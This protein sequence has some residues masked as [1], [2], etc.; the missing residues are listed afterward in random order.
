MEQLREQ[1][2]AA[3]A[4]A[5]REHA[6]TPSARTSGQQDAAALLARVRSYNP[7]AS[8]RLITEAFHFAM[9][10][11]EGQ[12]RASGEPY[13]TH[14][15]AVAFIL[16]DL[17]MDDESI[18]AA[19]LHDVVED[20]AA[21]LEEIG[22]RFGPGVA[23]LVEGLTKI[24][25]LDLISRAA[26]QAENLRKFLIAV[27]R[28]VR[29][30]IIKLADRLHNMRTLMHVRPEKRRRIAQETMDIYAPLAARMGLH[31][32]REE[33]EDLAFAELNP[34]M[35]A[36]ILERLRAIRQQHAD[37]VD[38]IRRE[39]EQAL[40]AHGITGAE[41]G[42]REKQPYSIWRKMRQKKLELAQVTDILAFRVIVEEVDDCYRALGAVHQ[43]W[44]LVPGRLKDYISLPKRN[45]Y[46]SI[47]TTV[48][49][50]TGEAMELQIR[51][52]EMH[53]VAERG[54]AAHGLYKEARTQEESEA[55]YVPPKEVRETFMWLN[56]VVEALE[57]G[58][59]PQEVIEHT[60][61]ELFTDQVFCFTP[62]GDLIVLP[63]GAT[64]IDFA[65]AVHT[66]VGNSA[67]G[68]RINKRHASLLSRL[69]NG[70]E[71]EIITSKAQ[72]TP[73]EMWEKVAVTAR[74]R[75]AI[76]RATRQARRAEYIGLGEE[77]LE[78]WLTKF[79]QRYS[80]TLVARAFPRLGIDSVED[81]LEALGRG[82]LQ[83]AEVLQALGLDEQQ[84][85][86]A[87][88]LPGVRA[89]ETGGW[90]LD[91]DV[92]VIRDVREKRL[93]ERA[94]PMQIAMDTGAVP[95]DRIIG[96]VEDG[97][98]RIHPSFSRA[99]QRYEEAGDHRWMDLGWNEQAL[100]G[101]LFPARVRVVV[102]NE[103]GALAQVAGI[104]GEHGAN[105]ENLVMTQRASD[106][107]NFD[108][109]LE[110]RHIE[111]LNE[112]LFALQQARVVVEAERQQGEA[113]Q[114][115]EADGGDAGDGANAPDAP[116]RA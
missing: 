22:E 80:R 11:H 39:I 112:I 90:L 36:R 70:D 4:S 12:K 9:Q 106:L 42:G 3:A 93:R 110:V 7:R 76:R 115:E 29:V 49:G 14:P 65:Y 94:L 60:K 114:P 109:V 45:G 63:R 64:A 81:G 50:P 56:G 57:S 72:E 59:T 69:N 83:V 89:T 95:G 48:R 113:G 46:Q 104:I 53:E 17:H 52:R 21:T 96:I 37:V 111:H 75:A 100:G 32:I 73:P 30:L 43:R 20:T 67:V 108:I 1:H 98:I 71:V 101:R 88:E 74:A 35:R 87:A 78:Y 23:K 79:G 24:R 19:L 27:T 55:G 25:R 34:V 84:V 33:L 15:V 2:D 26:A 31:A 41:V 85:R 97:V 91:R 8:E 18:A 40:A 66:A 5:Q 107:Y 51:T 13:F 92:V 28:D 105:I 10:A 82:A 54:V 44:K 62:K 86:E 103:V 68:C 47:H 99:L 61:L 6:A 102:H 38:M 16:A 116:A 77:M 58:H